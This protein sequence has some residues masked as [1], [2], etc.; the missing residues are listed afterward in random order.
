L[1]DLLAHYSKESDGSPAKLSSKQ[2]DAKLKNNLEDQL[3]L[4]NNRKKAA[5]SPDKKLS[6][7]RS[8]VMASKS[9]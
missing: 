5:N 2:V 1:K 3:R 6:R 8:S 7:R 9:S 4:L